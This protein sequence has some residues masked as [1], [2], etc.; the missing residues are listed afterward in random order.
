M[1]LTFVEYLISV[2]EQALVWFLQDVGFIVE[3]E[4]L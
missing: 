1:A 4:H 3:D 2:P